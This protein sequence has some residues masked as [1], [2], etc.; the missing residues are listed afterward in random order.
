MEKL[1]A[2]QET[3]RRQEVRKDRPSYK[4]LPEYH[5]T[6][7]PPEVADV[8]QVDR[9]WVVAELVFGQLP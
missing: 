9:A 7:R 4:R 5:P 1:F 8:V 6:S 2:C 3:G